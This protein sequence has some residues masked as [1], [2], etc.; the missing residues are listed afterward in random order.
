MTVEQLHPRLV[1][2]DADA[3]ISFYAAAFGAELLERYTDGSG[4][5]VHALLRAGPAVWAVKDADDVD[6]APTGAGAVILAL[7]VDDPDAVAA[8]MVT[9][10]GRVVFEVADH[11]YGDRA[12][13]IAD[14][15][16]HVW[17]VAARNEELDPE[18]I[19]QRT[20]TAYP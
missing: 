4:R 19:Q 2:S 6:Q 1:V 16:G 12:G 7:Y 10:G 3:A 20:A 15:Y 18:Q 8:A 14:P 13:R 11:S 5:V 17:M 9:G